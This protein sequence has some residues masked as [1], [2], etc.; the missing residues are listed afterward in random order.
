MLAKSKALRYSQVLYII[1]QRV[2]VKLSVVL[3][4]L[5]LLKNKNLLKTLL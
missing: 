1:H 3:N 5:H 2:Q 4:M